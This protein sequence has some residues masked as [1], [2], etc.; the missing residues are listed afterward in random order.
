MKELLA[1][2]IQPFCCSVAVL[3]AAWLAVDCMRDLIS[4]MIGGR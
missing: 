2:Y 3:G 1:I 4:M